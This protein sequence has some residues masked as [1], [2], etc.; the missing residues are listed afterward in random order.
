MSCTC[1]RY[2]S[3]ATTL[4]WACM[5]ARKYHTP[6]RWLFAIAEHIFTILLCSILQDN[7]N[8]ISQEQKP[9]KTIKS[10]PEPPV[11]QPKRNKKKKKHSN[12]GT[13]CDTQISPRQPQLKA[14]NQLHVV[15]TPAMV[16]T[17][18]STKHRA[19][20]PTINVVWNHDLF[21][22]MNENAA[23]PSPQLIRTASPAPLVTS[24]HNKYL[25]DN[26][27]VYQLSDDSLP[28]TAS[29]IQIQNIITMGENSSAYESSEDTGV[30]ELSESELIT[31]QDGI[32][33]FKCCWSTQVLLFHTCLF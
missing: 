15:S 5:E 13:A 24:V 27:M 2:K 18:I 26:V 1:F 12:Q 17:T 31:A 10:K 14:T 9:K 23:P 6:I 8:R 7:Y 21:R 25:P 29:T 11:R 3:W 33:R 30:G 22:K 4:P 20:T 16:P 32:G 28:Q 19:H